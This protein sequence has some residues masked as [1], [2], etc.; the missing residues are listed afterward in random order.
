MYLE[1]KNNFKIE[2][3]DTSTATSIFADVQTVEEV[4]KI[5]QELKKE[6]NL[7]KFK[8]TDGKDETFGIYEKYVYVAT[9]YTEDEK[10]IHAV[11]TLRAKSD[12]EIEVEELKKS[13]ELLLNAVMELSANVYGE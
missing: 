4:D 1:L 11:Y 7:D 9:G 3:K 13:D 2:V 5:T 8:F 6:G 12:L 10:G